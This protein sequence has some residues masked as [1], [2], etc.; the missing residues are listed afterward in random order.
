MIFPAQLLAGP[1]DDIQLL[2]PDSNYGSAYVQKLTNVQNEPKTI[3][4]PSNM[5]KLFLKKD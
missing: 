3:T 4:N 5:F 1:D 2:Y